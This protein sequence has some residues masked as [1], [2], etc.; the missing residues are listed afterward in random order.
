MV[1]PKFIVIYMM[2]MVAMINM[3]VLFI[4][5]MAYT[6]LPLMPIFYIVVLIMLASM[7]FST[8]PRAKIMIIVMMTTFNVTFLGVILS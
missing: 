5:I 1:I 2:P 7:M 3:M 4:M 6:M 8:I